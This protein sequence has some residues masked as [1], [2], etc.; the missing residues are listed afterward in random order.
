MALRFDNLDQLANCH[1]MVRDQLRRALGDLGKQSVPEA[2]A[3][4]AKET[5][6][7][8]ARPEQDAGELLVEW[9]QLLVLPNGL[10][11]WDFFYHVPNGGFR[12]PIEA[13]IFYGQGVRKGWPDYGLDLP[14]GGYHG[15]RMELKALSG[16]KP[17]TEQLDI[18]ARLESVGYY[19]CVAWGFDEARAYVQGYL[20]RLVVPAAAPATAGR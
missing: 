18:L 7:K 4:I 11:P 16:A 13:K 19:C 15:F 10:K 8:R 12:N 6:A 3:A 2:L 20:D 9:L 5:P 14:A 1:P 17:S